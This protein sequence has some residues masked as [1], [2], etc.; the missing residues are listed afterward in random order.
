MKHKTRII[1]LSVVIPALVAGA[2][3]SNLF[4]TESTAVFSFDQHYHLPRLAVRAPYNYYIIT[5]SVIPKTYGNP[6]EFYTIGGSGGSTAPLFGTTGAMATHYPDSGKTENIPLNTYT[7][8]SSKLDYGAIGQLPD[9]E[10]LLEKCGL[11]IYI[12]KKPLSHQQIK[13]IVEKWDK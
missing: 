6:A 10:T 1:V 5:F 7:K 12:A 9:D 8:L 13:A 11:Y 3:K 4:I 2:L